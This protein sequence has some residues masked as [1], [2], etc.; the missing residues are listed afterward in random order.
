M[1]GL[2]YTLKF[3]LSMGWS[4]DKANRVLCIIAGILHLCQVKFKGTMDANRQEIVV[5]A[6]DRM[7]VEVV[8]LLGLDLAKLI[9]A[10]TIA[11]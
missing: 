6:G 1:D 2:K 4:D 3:M 11:S 8:K 10:L 9:T 5:I 7:V